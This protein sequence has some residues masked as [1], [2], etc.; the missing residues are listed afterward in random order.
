MLD[1]LGGGLRKALHKLASSVF[2]DKKVVEDVIKQIKRTLLEADVNLELVNELCEKVRKKASEKVPGIE[3]KEQIIKLIHDE[4]VNILGAKSFKLEIDRKKKPYKIMLIGL[5]GTGK[6]TTTV[7]LAFYY[8]KRNYKVCVLGLDTHRQAAPEQLEQLAKKA[9]VACFVDKEEKNALSVW[10]KFSDKLKKYDIVFIDTAGRD[11]LSKGLINELKTLNKVINPE[12]TF[13]VISADIGKAA[14]R[15]AKGFSQACK[16][17]GIIVTKLDGTAKAGGA[18]SS[19]KEAKANVVFITTGEKLYDIE[20]FDAT[21]FVSRLLGLGDLKA[22]VEKARLAFEEKER[23]KLEKRLKAETF[24]LDDLYE[25]IK[26]M[27]KIGPLSKIAE[28]IP[29]FSFLTSRASKLFDVQ[30]EKLKRWKYAIDSMTKEERENPEMINASRLARISKGS[31]VSA[32]EIRELLKQYKIM[33]QFI[34]ET[35]LEQ[36]IDQRTLQK[37]A[38]KFGKKLF[39]H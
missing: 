36:G 20:S 25:Q 26:A 27:Q 37:L 12:K 17:D 31:A 38:K 16:I 24:T 8:S 14:S 22:L 1:K 2:V 29:G 18:L 28:M 3:K 30:E 4:L 6:T 11:T 21:S 7:K 23:K 33:K 34:S 35:N 19:C 5:Y 9:N 39:L 10:K 32:G 13:L 15:L